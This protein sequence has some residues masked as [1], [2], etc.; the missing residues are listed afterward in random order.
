MP[1]LHVVTDDAVLARPD[2]VSVASALLEAGGPEAALHIRG[3][4]TS[5]R[6]LFEHASALKP[7]A[8]HTSSALFIND[9]VDVALAMSAHG[10]QLGTRSMAV[11]TARGLL[12]PE[13]SIGAS[14]HDPSEAQTADEEGA[15]FAFV[16]T[17]FPSHSHPDRRSSGADLLGTVRDAVDGLPLIG[18]GGIRVEGVEYVLSLGAVGVAVIGGIWGAE[19]PREAVRAYLSAL[20]AK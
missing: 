20:R 18:I 5:G 11:G 13:V 12:G 15:D 10:V 14:T 19:D 4:D 9:R 1:R 16:G 3:H 17:L 8:E 7:V 2:F 6:A